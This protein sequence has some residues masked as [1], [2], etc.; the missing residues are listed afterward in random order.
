MPRF[1]YIATIFL[2]LIA[3][4]AAVIAPNVTPQLL[5]AK[6][7]IEAELSARMS[8]EVAFDGPMRLRFLPAPQLIIEDLRLVRKQ[9][10]ADLMAMRVPVMVARLSIA[11]LLQNRAKVTDIALI[12]ADVTISIAENIAGFLQHLSG[13]DRPEL[14][15]LDARVSVV[16]LNAFRPQAITTVNRLSIDISGGKARDPLRLIA[17]HRMPDGQQA[18]GQMQ[19]SG[20]GPQTALQIELALG[21]GEQV[22]FVGQ[23]TSRSSDWQLDGEISLKSAELLASHVE[24][25]L[26]LAIDGEAR[27][28]GLSG[29]IR[30]NKFGLSAETVEVDLLNTVFRSRLNLEWPLAVDARPLLSGRLTTGL[31]DL[32]VL[33]YGKTAKT[34]SGRLSALWRS[35]APALDIDLRVEATRFNLGGEAGRDLFLQFDWRDQRIDIDRFALNLPFSSTLLLAGQIDLSRPRLGFAGNFSARSSDSL[36]AMLWAGG[37]LG[38][39]LAGFAERLDEA[40][41]QRVSLV[42][43]ALVNDSGFAL[44]GVSGRIGDD[45]LTAD[46][47]LSDPQGPK[48][49]AIMRFDRLDFADWG[50]IDDETSVRQEESSAIWQQIGRELADILSAANASR[51]IVLDVE[52]NRTF[53]GARPLGAVAV[54]ADIN[55]QSLSLAKLTIDGTDRSRVAAQGALSFSAEPYFGELKIDLE[56]PVGGQIENW[57]FSGFGPLQLAG[58][59]PAQL[60]ANISFSGPDA[61]D[62]PRVTAV[63]SGSLGKLRADF[64]ASTPSRILL[65]SPAGSN[66]SVRLSGSANAMAAALDLPE[67][68]RAREIGALEIDLQAQTN[69]VS[70]LLGN[71]R[72]A[73][74]AVSLNGVLRP[75]LAGARLEGALDFSFGNSL[76]LL[77]IDRPRTP[78]GLIGKTQISATQLNLSFSALEMT[79]GDGMISGEGVLKFDARLPQLNMTID[80]DGLDVSWALPKREAQGW[81]ETPMQW[82]LLSL[83]NADIGFKADNLTLGQVRLDSFA[84]RVKVTDGV[85]EAPDLTLSAWQGEGLVNLQAEGGDLPPRFNLESSFTGINPAGFLMSNFGNRLVDAAFDGGI[86]MNGRGSS[87]ANM[88]RSLEGEIRY[89]IRPGA[90]SIFDTV[91]F[92]DAVTRPDFS[93]TATA[94]AA[95]YQ[96]KDE[97]TFARGLGLAAVREGLLDGS[98]DFVFAEGLN[99]AQLKMTMDLL[100]LQLDGGFT[101]YPV[102][103]QRPVVWQISGAVSKPRTEI[104]ASAFDVIS[105]PAPNAAPQPAR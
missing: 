57:L 15:L 92:G 85:L 52:V 101:L 2:L 19:I 97:L 100:S 69:E 103:R 45:F 38:V 4:G 73:D 79:L 88:M 66:M 104:D 75:A 14:S 54:Q 48:F 91:G 98:N 93:G 7:D 47:M 3:I 39:D 95:Q 84:G 24:R 42:G 18:L 34:G 17:R 60:T 46:L 33:R 13:Q 96:G 27:Q 26:P 83:G 72:M 68:Y 12:E 56:D 81:R 20:A 74:D 70:A 6:A 22:S 25:N 62:W 9:D 90:I 49:D 77:G 89:E 41:L 67:I 36:A 32:D 58:D 50:V 102:D 87:V 11:D 44:N 78:L 43:D 8:A 94:L 23:L 63:G 55:D 53:A 51:K 64:E 82:S 80:A 71:L 16:G 21:R 61:P 29:I 37:Q 59:V 105:A 76:P 31:V 30:G 28:V 35:F 40:R 86:K 1:P 65:L 99:E 5:P 10:D